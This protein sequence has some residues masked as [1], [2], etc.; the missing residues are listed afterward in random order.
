MCTQCSVRKHKAQDL[1]P[2]HSGRISVRC[3]KWKLAVQRCSESCA[4]LFLARLV[5]L[6][7]PLRQPAVR[8]VL[9]AIILGMTI[10]R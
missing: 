3:N 4:L 6:C 1:P 8:H 7:G 5:D 10:G 2:P 9:D